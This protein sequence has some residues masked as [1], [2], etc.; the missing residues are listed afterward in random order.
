ME[1][2]IFFIKVTFFRKEDKTEAEFTGNDI[3]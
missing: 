3:Q 1:H 2:A